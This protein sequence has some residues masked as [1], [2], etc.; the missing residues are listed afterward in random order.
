[1]D[2]YFHLYVRFFLSQSEN[3]HCKRQIIFLYTHLWFQ[4]TRLG[5]SDILWVLMT[6]WAGKWT[7]NGVFLDVWQLIPCHAILLPFGILF[8]LLSLNWRLPRRFKLCLGLSFLSN[9]IF[10]KFSHEIYRER[11]CYEN[12]KKAAERNFLWETISDCN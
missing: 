12:D 8:G 10:N 1:M 2:H 5:N 7:S 3:I 9:S 11:Y 4:C 6:R